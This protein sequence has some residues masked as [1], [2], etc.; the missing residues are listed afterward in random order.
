MHKIRSLKRLYPTE[1]KEYDEISSWIPYDLFAKTQSRSLSHY[2]AIAQTSNIA[3]ALEFSFDHPGGTNRFTVENE[4]YI[5]L[6]DYYIDEVRGKK[7]NDEEKKRKMKK[8]VQ[9]FLK[10]NKEIQE[11]LKSTLPR[12]LVYFTPSYEDWGVPWYTTPHTY[13]QNWLGKIYSEIRSQLT[14]RR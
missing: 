12:D 2:N 11:L 9:A 14:S 4:K 5:T 1:L 6:N 13:D 10:E 7:S 3:W 8:A